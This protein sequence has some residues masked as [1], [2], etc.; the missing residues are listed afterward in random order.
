MGEGFETGER[1]SS[2]ARG[3]AEEPSEAQVP[4]ARAGFAGAQSLPP[5]VKAMK[6]EDNVHV[7]ARAAATMRSSL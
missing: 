3:F 7:V 2:G 1:R 5:Q 4:S 6:V